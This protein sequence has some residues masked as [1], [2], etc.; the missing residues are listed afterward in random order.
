MRP[1][2]GRYAVIGC[3]LQYYANEGC[4]TS[5]SL[6]GLLASFIVQYYTNE[7][8]SRSCDKPSVV[9]KLLSFNF[10]CSVLWVL[11]MLQAQ[12]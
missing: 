8:C 10:Y 11:C 9:T 6:A 7:G 1:L 2:I 5:A 4:K 3:K 12:Q